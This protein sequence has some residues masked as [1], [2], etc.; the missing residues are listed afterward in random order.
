M[1][2][3]MTFKNI[4][5]MAVE[6][7]ATH[8]HVKPDEPI[9]FRV[10][11]IVEQVDVGGVSREDIFS[12]VEECLYPEEHKYWQNDRRA[13]FEY[14]IESVGRFRVHVF[15]QRG[16]PSV[17]FQIVKS[18][19]PGF[20]DMGLSPTLMKPICQTKSGLILLSSSSLQ[21][22]NDIAAAML[23]YINQ[24]SKKHILCIEDP[25]E[26]NF[27]DEKSLFSQREIGIDANSFEQAINDSLYE[28]ADIV[29]I[30]ALSG[31]G[32]IE[33]ILRLVERGVLVVVGISS[34]SVSEAVGQLIAALP[35]ARGKIAFAIQ[36]VLQQYPLLS[37]EGKTLFA[38]EILA[39]SIL[40]EKILSEGD[41]NKIKI[42]VDSGK[43][44]NIPLVHSV[45]ELLSGEKISKEDAVRLIESQG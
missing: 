29:F 24:T 26:Y 15:M 34:Q 14:F 8:I 37:L 1:N 27:I 19:P 13:N 30:S 16:T 42:L 20:E 45:Q 7:Q 41:L 4:L 17:V 44:G 2:A 6:N 32:S 33:N 23:D 10:N 5:E 39:K 3:M 38:Q 40:S 11:E 25:I 43:E 35:S 9:F 28:N 21:G 18:D 36:F 22:R 31:S 12:F